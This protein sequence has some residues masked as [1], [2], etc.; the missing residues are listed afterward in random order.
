MDILYYNFIAIGVF[1]FLATSVPTTFLIA[2]MLLRRNPAGNPVKNTPYESAEEPIGTVRDVD[3][4][5]L[6]FFAIF[7]PFEIISLVLVLW[8]GSARGLDLGTNFM[9]MGL[10]VASMFLALV[11]YKFAVDK[12]V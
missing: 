12:N 10:A 7:L 9:I 2:S 4:E 3:N 1:F 8:A 6:P 11:G 5:Y